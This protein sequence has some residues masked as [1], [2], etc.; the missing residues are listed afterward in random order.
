MVRILIAAAM[1]YLIVAALVYSQQSKF[2]YPAPQGLV[3]AQAGYQDVA[4][5]TGD[6]LALR[7]FY[8]PAAEGLP[9]AVY[10]HGNGGTLSGSVA[11]TARLAQEGYGLLLVEYR[12][13]GGNAG[14]PGEEGFYLDGRAALAFIRERGIAEGDIVLIGNSIG[15]ATALKMATEIAPKALIL[16]A[17]FSSL[18]EIAGE[19]MWWLPVSLLLTD[20]FDN[21]AN[22][23]K[24]AAP[25]LIQHGTADTLI[26]PHHSE[27]LAAAN[28]AATYQRFDGAGHNLIFLP[29]TQA[30]QYNWLEALN[31]RADS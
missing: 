1:I 18:T 6:G 20:R 5:E 23:A 3:P 19:K 7:A 30:S 9:T 11:A 12:G 28:P 16:S 25:V 10:F 4:L 27:A 17:P 29:D 31:A 26:P 8:K 22:I 14:D 13:Y 21:A 2:I 24:V 15:C